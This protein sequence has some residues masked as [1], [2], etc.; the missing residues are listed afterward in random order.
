MLGGGACGG[1]AFQGG[2]C[3]GGVA[4]WRDRCQGAWPVAGATIAMATVPRPSC[5]THLLWG[6][7]IRR[8]LGEDDDDEEE[9]AEPEAPALVSPTPPPPTQAPPTTGPTHL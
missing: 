6:D 9:G 7:L 1:Q 2:H 5:H 3:W 8:H 4:C